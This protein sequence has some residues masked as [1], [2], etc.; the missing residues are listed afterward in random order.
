MRRVQ[1][2]EV[3]VSASERAAAIARTEPA[4]AGPMANTR[5]RQPVPAEPPIG[6]GIS[7]RASDAYVPQFDYLD[8]FLRA[9][10]ARLTLGLSPHAIAAAWFDWALHVFRSPGRMLDLGQAAIAMQAQLAHYAA[11][12]LTGKPGDPPLHPREGDRRFTAPDWHHPPACLLVQNYLALEQWWGLATSQIRGMDPK[13]AER[14]A[15]MTSQLLDVL[16]PTNSPLNPEIVERTFAQGGQN[17]IRGFEN[18]TDDLVREIAGQPPR[19][20]SQL[21]VGRDLAVTPGT[22]VYRNHLFELIQY[23]P[24]TD[25]VHREPVLIVPAW[26]M[27]YYI[28]DLRPENS[29]VGYLVGRGHTV[30][31]MS[32]LNPGPEQRDVSLD[33]YRRAVMSAID[34]TAGAIGDA[35]IHLAGYCLGG[36]IAAIVA[37]TMAR[38]GDQRLASLTLLAAQTDFSEAGELMLFVDESQT[39]F[40]EDMMW[41][42]GVL[43]GRQMSG[44]FQLLRSN[45]L[46]WSRIIRDYVL[47]ERSEVFDIQ[48][49]SE[50]LTRMPYKMHSQYLRGL[51]L[52]NR[53]TAGRFAV[54]GRVIALK[55]IEAPMFV[56]GTESDH[57]APWRSVYKAHLFTDNEMTFVLTNGGHNAGIVSEPGHKHRH[58]RMSLR[59]PLDR[60]RDPDTWSQHAP[61]TDGSWWPAWA[62]WLEQRSTGRV[63]R[64]DDRAAIGE[65]FPLGPA[66]GEYVLKR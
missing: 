9:G 8:R 54:D 7:I 29:L 26:I 41:A 44:A 24:A 34:A 63:P 16:A 12:C 59:K 28:L 38:D 22:V 57:I 1:D 17:L 20:A 35:R 11:S 50:D 56:V 55:D 18:I 46:V 39:T 53:L 15:F 61:A 62:D 13:H 31:M 6:D 52:E 21:K 51:F 60:Y 4:S 33:D 65:F 49:W 14:V 45:E 42:Q 64:R 66:P 32:W 37:S 2:R 5:G 58:Y 36:T 23:A 47:G 25:D 30:L 10:T 19:S 40:L 43:R 27:K 48:A 3:D